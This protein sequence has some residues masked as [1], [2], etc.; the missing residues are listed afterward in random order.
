ML[1]RCAKHYNEQI[2]VPDDVPRSAAETYD[3]DWPLPMEAQGNGAPTVECETE[4][5]AT[6]YLQNDTPPVTYEDCQ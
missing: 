2:P 4:T 3:M 6:W 5:H 1:Q